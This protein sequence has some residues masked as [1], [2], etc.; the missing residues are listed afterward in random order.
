[1]AVCLEAAPPSPVD[2]LPEAEA[3]T[4]RVHCS[5]HRPWHLEGPPSIFVEEINACCVVHLSHRPTFSNRMEKKNHLSHPPCL[6]K[7]LTVEP[8]LVGSPRGIPAHV[9]LQVGAGNLVWCNLS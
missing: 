9:L 6:P 7:A 1:M 5:T 4:H 2:A 8:G 3:L